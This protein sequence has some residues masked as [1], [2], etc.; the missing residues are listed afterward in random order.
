MSEELKPVKPTPPETS[1]E[2][3][4]VAPRT[5]INWRSMFLRHRWWFLGAA[6]ALVL[7]ITGYSVYAYITHR[8]T[9][10]VCVG[11]SCPSSTPN[12]DDFKDSIATPSPTPSLVEARLT[13]ELVE[14]G[15]ANLRPLAVVIE[16]HPEARPQS[17]LGN[18]DVVYEA[19]SEGGITRFLAVFGNAPS[20]VRVGPVRSARTYFVDYA[21][22]LGAF[23]AHVGGNIDAL[24]QIQATGVLDLDQFGVGAPTYQRD[25]SR[26]VA[27]EHTMYSSTEKLWEV[28]TVKRNWSSEATY[29]AWKFADDIPSESR[30]GA[31]AV[32]IAF[33]SPQYTASWAYEPSTNSYRRSMG[34]SPHVDANSN[35]VIE[36]KNIILQ[37]VDRQSVLTRQGKTVWKYGLTGSGKATVI[38]NGVSV[39][40][41]WKKEGAGRTRY[42]A[43]DGSELLLTRGKTWVEIIHPDTPVTI[44]SPTPTPTQ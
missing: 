44:T 25:L 32:T 15:A 42:F 33:S 1:P 40:A 11:T 27:L 6:A 34:G 19:I 9:A 23:F 41:T 36:S 31:Q 26:N 16:N 4:T 22:E 24:D 30:P 18:A 8:N 21:T 5:R 7:V 17:G 3:L 20:P 38:R 12:P 28:A 39:T 10:V 35:S 13:G 2:G 43:E 14:S 37:T 29:D